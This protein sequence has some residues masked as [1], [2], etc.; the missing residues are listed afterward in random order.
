MTERF[1]S[2]QAAN[3]FVVGNDANDGL[4]KLTP[5]LTADALHAATADGDIATYNDGTYVASSGNQY[6]RFNRNAT[7]RAYN[8]GAVILQPFAGAT[9][10][11]A[12]SAPS[13]VG[14]VIFD[15]LIFD[16]IAA[17]TYVVNFG[18]TANMWIFRSCEARNGVAGGFRL[19]S[20]TGKFYFIDSKA[21]GAMNESGIRADAFNSGGSVFVD[22]FE[23]ALTNVTT[24]GGGIYVV[25]NAAGVTAIIQNVFGS[26]IVNGTSPSPGIRANNVSSLLIRGPGRGSANRGL[27]ISGSSTGNTALISATNTSSIATSR[28]VIDGFKGRNLTDKGYL[29]N[30]GNDGVTNAASDYMISDFDI[31]NCDVGGD[32]ASNSKHGIL[33]GTCNRGTIANN[34]ITGVYYGIVSK[35]NNG[36]TDIKC[37][38][39][40]GIKTGGYHIVSKASQG[41]QIAGNNCFSYYGYNAG[42]VE[43]YYDA[44]ASLRADSGGNCRGNNFFSDTQL[45]SG[46]EY[47][48]RLGS[49]T[50]PGDTSS[51]SFFGNNYFLPAGSGANT[52]SV[53]SATFYSSL[54]AWI[55]AQDANATNV[56][57]TR[58]N[59]SFY[60]A[61]LSQY[62]V[63]KVAIDDPWLPSAL[64]I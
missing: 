64:G 19:T 35:L 25:G 22:G 33:M 53:G 12:N 4:T 51:M 20:N 57:P 60:R 29:I 9:A 23:L 48:M 59:P 30:V 34:R 7:Y 14:T 63:S 58:L 8:K 17:T 1:V 38:E 39:T 42:F 3:G 43:S 47:T 27:T 18:N 46:G 41:N 26:M 15:G 16:G 36:D 24:T 10:Q 56:L 5:F 40:F 32:F 44:N 37:N 49:P 11:C 31:I 62:A 55:T 28:G 61:Q 50:L 54:A 13:G 21:A 6:H 2:N 52:F 45:A